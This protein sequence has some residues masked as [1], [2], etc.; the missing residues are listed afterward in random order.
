MMTI[1]GKYAEAKIFIDH[2]EPGLIEQVQRVL[3]NL[4]SDGQKNTYNA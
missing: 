3:D 1:K 2:T 4:I